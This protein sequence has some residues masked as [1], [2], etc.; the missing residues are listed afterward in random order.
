[1][2]QIPNLLYKKSELIN[3]CRHK[4]KFLI[5]GFNRNRYSDRSDAVD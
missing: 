5:K 3:A 1:M 2:T 4:S